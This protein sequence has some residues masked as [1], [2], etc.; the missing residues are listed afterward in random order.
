MGMWL[1]FLGAGGGG[2][3]LSHFVFYVRGGAVDASG[4]RSGALGMCGGS[5][6]KGGLY[7]LC[8]F[9]QTTQLTKLG[10][11]PVVGE[12]MYLAQFTVK[13]VFV[14]NELA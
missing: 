10:G 6:P 5:A 4:E 9:V 13:A 2:P 14:N 7:L 8:I 3:F 11:N 1:G 12:A